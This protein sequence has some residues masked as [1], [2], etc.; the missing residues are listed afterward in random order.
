MI[1]FLY[2]ALLYATPAIISIIGNIYVLF[3]H[4]L[5]D[6]REWKLKNAKTIGDYVDCFKV[7]FIPVVNILFA[8]VY[9]CMFLYDLLSWLF[10]L[11]IKATK[12]DILW[13]KI[14]NIK[15]RK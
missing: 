4:H 9:L 10:K 2:I 15:I 12:L 7:S 3:N 5:D 6:W 1:V 13:N 14:M 8:F 11:I